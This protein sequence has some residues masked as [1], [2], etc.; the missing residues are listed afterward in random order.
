MDRKN[1]SSVLTSGAMFRPVS[2]PNTRTGL[3][4]HATAPPPPPSSPPHSMKGIFEDSGSPIHMYGHNYHHPPPHHSHTHMSGTQTGAVS[5]ATIAASAVASRNANLVNDQAIRQQLT[6][7][8][9]QLAD[10]NKKFNNF[11][12]EDATF[13]IN[14]L[15]SIGKPTQF[16]PAIKS[17]S[18]SF[19]R[20]S[21]SL[22][23]P[24]SPT[25]KANIVTN[26][27]TVT[28]PG[29][30]VTLAPLDV[31][32]PEA[33]GSHHPNKDELK[34]IIKE[35]QSKFSNSSMSDIMDIKTG[36]SDKR[37]ASVS[38]V[39]GG[40]GNSGSNVADG[41][42]SDEEDE[43]DIYHSMMHGSSLRGASSSSSSSSTPSQG[44]KR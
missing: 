19:G 11:L 43:R 35:R 28:K 40:G 16:Q 32:S 26:P 14:V 31:T 21:G 34:V 41:D 5:A 24:S 13:K 7:L 10:L 17:A 4:L 6:E 44:N 12:N 22:S 39:G 1:M 8:S 20:G 33:V 15:A 38:A 18:G 27:A 9:K 23:P 42:D 36:M 37:G 3:R 30:Q 29:G 2:P 25:N